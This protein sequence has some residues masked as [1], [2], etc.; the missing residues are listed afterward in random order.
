LGSTN[1]HD[2]LSAGRYRYAE[3]VW[4]RKKTRFIWSAS[5]A[6]PNTL[7]H[8]EPRQFH[9]QCIDEGDRLID[10]TEPVWLSMRP[11]LSRV[12]ISSDLCCGCECERVREDVDP[13]LD[14]SGWPSQIRRTEASISLMSMAWLSMMERTNI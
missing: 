6:A 13:F 5:R 11:A 2:L 8:S 12:K 7:A 4:R 14:V 1:G 3:R 9:H 10:V